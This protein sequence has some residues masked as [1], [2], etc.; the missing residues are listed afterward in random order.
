MCAFFLAFGEV[1]VDA[2]ELGFAVDRADVGVFVHWVADAEA[3]HAEFE[4]LFDFV[5]NRFL[6]EQARARAADFAL[7]E[8]DALD[9]A[10]DGLV[11]ACVVED[12]VRGLAAKFECEFLF[13]V[14]EGFGD[15]LANVGAAGE[16]DF[17]DAGVIDDC[18]AC[19]AVACHDVDDAFGE[20]DFM[21][22]FGEAEGG[23]R[24]RFGGF[25]NDGV[26]AGEGGCE[27]PCAHEQ[28]EVP[29]D[30]LAADADGLR[31]PRLS[32]PSV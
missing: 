12:D 24:C 8:V 22:D 18:R 28:R 1:V 6:H 7:V 29:R 15:F 11:D 17:V 27:F 32:E 9:N 30:D 25:E 23:E 26:A 19:L 3:G 2:V 31:V 16:G 5:K 20:T 14:G 21:E 10:F 4:F 13:G